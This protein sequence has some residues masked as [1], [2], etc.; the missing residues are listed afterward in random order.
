MGSNA[1]RGGRVL[2]IQPD[3]MSSALLSE[4][5]LADGH[6]VWVAETAQDGVRQLEDETFDIVLLDL[7][8]ADRQ[9]FDLLKQIRS[10]GRG[11]LT[12]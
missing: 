8:L 7:D 3:P 1:S 10:T 2:V 6:K 5:L 11:E 4:H 12:V 9:G